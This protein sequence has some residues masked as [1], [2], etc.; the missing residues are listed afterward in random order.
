V[1]EDAGSGECTGDG[2][3][4]GGRR[5]RVRVLEFVCRR[6]PPSSSGLL[7][8]IWAAHYT[9]IPLDSYKILQILI[10]KVHFV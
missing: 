7:R 8:S 10:Y 6:R 4:G 9:I 2:R 3:D 1:E 5:G